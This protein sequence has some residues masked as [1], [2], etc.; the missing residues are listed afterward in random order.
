MDEITN[1]EILSDEPLATDGQPSVVE[2]GAA[3][4]NQETNSDSVINY[5]QIVLDLGR[6]GRTLGDTYSESNQNT[7]EGFVEAL[8][9]L[10]SLSMQVRDA[11]ASELTIKEKDS[12]KLLFDYLRGKLERRAKAVD[13]ND[14]VV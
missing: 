11:A 7:G 3:N 13:N 12:L 5:R 14:F 1:I 2:Q 4:A 8:E 6:I 10:H 9:L